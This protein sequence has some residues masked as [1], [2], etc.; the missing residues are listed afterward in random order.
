MTRFDL[1][2]LLEL[3]PPDVEVLAYDGDVSFV[4][5]VTG[6]AYSE[7]DNTLELTTDDPS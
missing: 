6:M 7:Q 1:V 3:Y 4:V 2:K 5:P